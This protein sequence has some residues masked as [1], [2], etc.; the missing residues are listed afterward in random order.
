VTQQSIT[1]LVAQGVVDGLEA[2]QVHEQHRDRAAP[3]PQ[4]SADELVQISA[5]GQ[6]G[7]VV[8]PGTPERG[9]LSLDAVGDVGVGD[10]DPAGAVD[11]RV[12]DVEPDELPLD[13]DGAVVEEGVLGARG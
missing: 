13:R 6:V 12:L 3:R 5:V 7:Q 1:H 10:H 2:V 4:R 11:P 9:L 8:V